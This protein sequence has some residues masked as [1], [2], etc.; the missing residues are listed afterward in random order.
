[1]APTSGRILIVDDDKTTA[2]MFGRLMTALGYEVVTALSGESAL[3]SVAARSP[4]LVMMDVKMGGIDGF[5]VCRRLKSDPR[6]RLVPIILVTG[7]AGT[8][9]RV[10]GI[11]VGADGFLTKPPELAELKA[12]V[13]SLT[14]M[15]QHLDEL[16]SAESVMASLALTI[17]AR[18][19]YTL[20]HCAR[21]ASYPGAV[22]ED[23][24]LDKRQLSALRRG[25]FL[26]DV[27]KIAIPDAVLLKPGRLTSSEY[28][29]MQQHTVVGATLCAE[30]RS[31]EDVV[32]IV[33]HH[34][35][36]SDGTGYPDRLR[37]DA[38]ALLARIMGVVDAYD[39]MT[40]ERPYKRAFAADDAFRELREEVRNGWREATLVDALQNIVTGTPALQSGQAS[41]A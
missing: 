3:R 14:R 23:L 7:L 2:E 9:N 34:H 19:P 33:R 18:D 35:E 40:T 30:L 29:L 28:A 8:A 13:K 25:G 22:G 5:E 12:Q 41:A 4:D 26:H 24:G 32:P 21:L 20:G 10:R 39:A 15:K 31:L 6:T 11:E 36:R 37:G 17:E 1:M 38:I 16:D 27:G